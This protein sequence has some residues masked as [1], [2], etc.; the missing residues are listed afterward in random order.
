MNF[1]SIVVFILFSLITYNLLK[2]FVL[3]NIKVNAWLILSLGI[4]LC[5]V[6]LFLKV[7]TFVMYI[8]QW[9][10]FVL[11]LWFVDLFVDNRRKR[12]RNKNNKVMQNKPK[13]KPNR[14]KNKG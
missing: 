14:I 5:V 9:L 6:S 4:I 2:I 12:L 11:I 3:S 1:L 13:V 8:I 7:P 10:Y